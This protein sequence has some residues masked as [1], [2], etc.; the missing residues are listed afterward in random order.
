MKRY[1]KCFN[2]NYKHLTILYIY[3]YLTICC[4]KLTEEKERVHRIANQALAGKTN[5]LQS[6]DRIQ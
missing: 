6:N 3:S 2:I 5:Q 4:W 1:E